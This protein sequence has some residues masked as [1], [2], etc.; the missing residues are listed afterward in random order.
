MDKDEAMARSF[1]QMI[2]EDFSGMILLSKEYSRP[3]LE[4]KIQSLS[5][6]ILTLE[7]YMEGKSEK[8]WQ[9]I[10]TLAKEGMITI[11]EIEKLSL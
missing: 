4:K 5:L 6:F 11:D 10:E 8:R 3:D 2:G 1:Y 7:N 9:E